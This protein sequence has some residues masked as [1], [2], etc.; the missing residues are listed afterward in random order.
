MPTGFEV[1]MYRN[2]EQMAKAQERIAAT[3]DRIA[4]AMEKARAEEQK[5]DLAELTD[6][7]QTA[8]DTAEGGSND[9]EIEALR[10]ALDV[11]LSLVPG[12]KG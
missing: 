1:T 6:A 3:L 12:W 11:A 8:D 7:V 5:S 10:N 9:E 4:A 2:I